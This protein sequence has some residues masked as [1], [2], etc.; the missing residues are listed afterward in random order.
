MAEWID[1]LDPE[2]AAIEDVLPTDIHDDVVDRLLAPLVHDDEPRPRLAGRRTYVFGVL[3]TP[4]VL[5]EQA[6]V[7]FHARTG[8]DRAKDD[9][10]LPAVGS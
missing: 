6:K 3:V 2:R 1:L 7:Y 5:P 4:V 10:S 9:A 8:R